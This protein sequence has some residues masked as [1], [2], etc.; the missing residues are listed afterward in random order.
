MISNWLLEG[1]LKEKFRVFFRNRPAL[2]LSSLLVLHFIGLMYT[3]DFSYATRDIRIKIP[4]FI[5]PLIISTSGI[6]TEKVKH[7]VLK[8]LVAAVAVSTIISTLILTDVIHREISDVRYVS[9]FTSH[10]RMALL[11]CVAIF[12]CAWFFKHPLENRWRYIYAGAV[13]WF[14]LFLVLVESMTGF[15]ALLITAVTFGICRLTRVKS[16]RIKLLTLGI[17]LL[18]TGLG[19]YCFYSAYQKSAVV[20]NVDVSRL[21]KFTSLGNPYKHERIT[22]GSPTENGHYVWIYYSEEE[23]KHSW[24]KRSDYDYNWKDMRGNVI[25]Y[26]LMRFLASKG[27]RKDGEGLSKLTDEEIRAIEKGIA[28]VDY[29]SP[30]KGRISEIIWEL[31]VYNNSGEVNGHSITQR[32]EY[33]KAACSII[34]KNPLIGVGTGDVQSA[35]DRQYEESR[36][37]L[38]REWRLRS[39]NQYLTIAVTFGFIGLAWFIFTLIYPAL[40]LGRFSD[41]LY[42]SFFVIAAVS[43]LTEDTLETQVG[44]TFFAFLNSFLL[45]TPGRKE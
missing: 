24:N 32:F 7:L 15:S 23:L 26:T 13:A 21:D 22:P 5:L 38:S 30:L 28:N 31:R 2:I 10:I 27:L 35:F 36:S 25:R 42:L 43:F 19:G 16:P 33:W 44:V 41:F 8:F 18:L 29:M 14:L 4:L 1:G 20:D 34:S 12:C 37:P 45:F 39:H 6:V 3:T 11:I 40:K 17:G 9:I